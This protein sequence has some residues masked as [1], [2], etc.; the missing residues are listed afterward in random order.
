M[1]SFLTICKYVALFLAGEW[2]FSRLL[3]FD[4]SRACRIVALSLKGA[5]G[6]ESTKAAMGWVSVTAYT[7]LPVFILALCAWDLTTRKART[8]R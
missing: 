3:P 7:I 1:Q 4:W 6:L 8:A 2:F 5:P